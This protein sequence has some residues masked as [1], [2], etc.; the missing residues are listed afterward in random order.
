[1][2]IGKK[3]EKFVNHVRDYVTSNKYKLLH[4]KPL[5][6]VIPHTNFQKILYRRTPVHR[7]MKRVVKHYNCR[8]F[9][10]TT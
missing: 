4:D 3:R 7:R 10:L 6:K 8:V 9:K 1:M 5:K 2:N